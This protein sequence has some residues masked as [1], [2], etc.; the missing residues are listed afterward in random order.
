MKKIY[1]LLTAL[2]F[3]TAHAQTPATDPALTTGSTGTIS[4]TYANQT[5]QYTTV[6]AADGN[7]WS[8]QNLGSSQIATSATD[9]DAFGDLYQWGR[10]Q[11][12][13]QLRTSATSTNAPVPNN[14]SGIT[15]NSNF[16]TSDPTWWDNG[17]TD[18]KWEAA[19]PADANEFNGC[20]PCK[21]MGQGWRL[22]TEAEWQAVMQSE[23]ITNVASAFQ[24][25]LKLTV[26]GARNSS[27]NLYN[28]GVRGYYWS[29]TISATNPDFA[30]YLYYSNAIVNA[31]A[32]GFRDQGTSV[33]CIKGLVIIKPAPTSLTVNVYNGTPA[34]ITT[35]DGTIQLVAHV[36]PVAA[37]QTVT[38][39]RIAGAEFASV[40]ASG[41]VFAL[42]N[43]TVT[44]Q[45]VSTED[46]TILGTI[47]VVITNQV[48]APESLTIT[49]HDN[50][51]AQ[52]NTNNGTLQLNAA[53]LPAE[54]D[55]SLTWFI[56]T[57]SEFATVDTNGLVTATANGTVTVKAVSTARPSIVH[58][59]DIT[60]T[61]QTIQP[62]SLDVTV[63]ENASPRINT[64]GGTLQLIANVLPA[65]A[66]QDVTWSI[67]EGGAL[68]TI[69]ENGVV[70][71]SVNGS[72]TVQAVSTIDT[73]VVDTI[74]IL[75]INQ[76]MLSSAP[77][78]QA[79]VEWDVEPITRVQFAG[80]DN[81]S[82]ETINTTPAYERFINIT[83]NVIL[84]QTYTLNVEG[85]TAGSFIHDIRVFIDWNQNHVYDMDTEYYTTSLQSSTG[86][87]GIKATLDITV[88]P[89][90]LT[91]TTRMRIT[92]DQWNVYE[93]GEFD[94]C[95]S[96]YY[97]QVE[98][99]SLKV[100]APVAGIDEINKTDFTL[101]PN[102]TTDIVTIQAVNEIKSIE[103]YNLT[104]QLI[105]AG[106]TN[107]I[108]L[109]KA[110][111]GVYILK[112]SF[113]DGSTANQKIIKR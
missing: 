107:K 94:A 50:A 101:Y 37:E 77:Y 39:S 80:I 46:A 31:G 65:D 32:G 78:C 75:I 19:T 52:I 9:A 14:P 96:A 73:T 60:I 42:D 84:N 15:G 3:G 20:D 66:G 49:V 29:N 2:A 67:I 108:S 112:V 79:S 113:T 18:N 69:D 86:I 34:Q 89:T 1:L 76:D 26:A 99:Y 25:N 90:A 71:A 102:P 87:D 91:G 21:A 82:P 10:W 47:N 4:F 16:I 5:V 13:H 30:K 7:V 97:G 36:L 81:T 17:A 55:Q 95:T 106:T 24:S 88:P 70:T 27:G 38:W 11:D 104:G 28:V 33:R 93:E 56:V 111:T 35:N 54:A 12:G 63:P 109:G 40:N 43:G 22:P 85:N 57:G 44:V 6:R 61:N 53:I 45:A 83:G 41:V 59:I 51:A 62:T 110:A 48:I 64:V 103:A 74:T 8:Q 92:K 98:E 58:T 23:S 68:A 105:A 100:N 72:I